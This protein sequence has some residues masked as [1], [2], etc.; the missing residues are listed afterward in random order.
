MWKNQAKWKITVISIHNDNNIF[1]IGLYANMLP[2][3]DP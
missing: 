3:K 1:L 2:L